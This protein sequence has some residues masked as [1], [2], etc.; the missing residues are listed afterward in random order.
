MDLRAAIRSKSKTNVQDA[1]RNSNNV[2]SELMAKN[3]ANGAGLL[4]L[5]VSMGNVSVFE[6]LASEVKKRVSESDLAGLCRGSALMGYAWWGLA[7]SECWPRTC[8]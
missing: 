1:L 5:A 8:P 4:M 6:L 3:A 2:K 7:L